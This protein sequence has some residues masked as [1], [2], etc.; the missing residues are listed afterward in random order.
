MVNNIPGVII[1]LE[2]LTKGSLKEIGVTVKADM[3]ANCKVD[4]GNLR[5]SHAYRVSEDHVKIGVTPA[6]SYGVYVEF[7]QENK[8]GRPWMRRTLQEDT[9]KIK[10][11]IAKHLS[12]VG[13]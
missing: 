11:I 5:R 2:E 10:Q 13:D 6:A 4:T 3:M 7:K 9:D 1:A 12:K 8:G